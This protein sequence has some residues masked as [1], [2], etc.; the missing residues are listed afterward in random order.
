MGQYNDIRRDLL[1]K[2]IHRPKE[3][4]PLIPLLMSQK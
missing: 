4:I 1:P 3:W 2:V